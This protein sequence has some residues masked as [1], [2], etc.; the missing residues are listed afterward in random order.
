MGEGTGD[1]HAGRVRLMTTSYAEAIRDGLR[2]AMRADERVYILGEDVAE[3][4][5]VYGVT[6]GLVQEFGKRRVKNTPISEAAIIGE[7]IGASI[8]GLRPVAEIQF[9]DFLTTAFS[10]LVD[11]AGPYRF[12]LGTNLPFVVRAPMGGGL[13]IGPFHSKC[14]E[15]WFFHQPGLK[16]VCPSTPTDAKGLLQAA[17]E[18]ED[19]VLFFEHKKLYYERTE[20]VP[21]EKFSIPLGKACVRREG[22]DVTIVTYSAMVYLA[23]EAAEELAQEGID[24]E[25]IDLRTLAPLDEETMFASF[26]KTN[27]VIILHEARLTGGVGGEIESRIVEKCFDSLAAPPVR[28]AAKDIPVPFAPQLEDFYLPSKQDVMDAAKR[29]I[30]Y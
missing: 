16:I 4:G 9:S 17:I 14:P 29:L 26:R 24:A 10:T 12:R 15:A 27:R 7:A 11:V 21:P 1:S 5:G 2:T 20:D 3:Y 23:L 19:P 22:K 6:K 30:M 28:I 25:V 18:D 13:R 8:A